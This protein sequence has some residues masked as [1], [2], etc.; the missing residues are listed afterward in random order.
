MKDKKDEFMEDILGIVREGEQ[1]LLFTLHKKNYAVPVSK[2]KEIIRMQSITE[3]PNVPRY[4]KGVINLRG[5]IV[6]I[7]DTRCRLKFPEIEYTKFSVI[8]VVESNG[9]HFG[10][11]TDE[12]KGLYGIKENEILELNGNED[13]ADYLIG[14]TTV[15]EY[16]VNVLDIDK[17]IGE[18]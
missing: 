4:I 11:T 5:E 18:S 9:S 16:T 14:K 10:L 7:M 12:V 1:Y 17:L 15:S 8:I 2:I 6:Q 3:I 13:A